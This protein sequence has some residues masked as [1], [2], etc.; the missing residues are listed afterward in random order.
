[1]REYW[2]PVA[3][4][5]RLISG[6]APVRLRILGE[7]LVAFRSPSGVVGVLD[8][9]CPHRGASLALARNEDCGLRCIYHGWKFASDGS[10]RE[11]PTHRPETD[12]SRFPKR[13][14]PVHE[15]QGIVW[16]WLGKGDAPA[17]PRL[18]FT[19]LPD[20]HVITSTAVLNCNWLHP[21]E[22]L[23]D[24]FHAQILH[25]QSNRASVRADVY[26]SDSVRDAD[27]DELRFDY[28][29]MHVQRTP[30]GFTYANIDV[31]KQTE[32]HFIAPFIQHHATTP[33][34]ETDKALQI[35]VP[36]DDD[37]CLLWIIFYN[38]F[39]PLKPDGFAMKGLGELPDLNNFMKGMDDRRAENFW[40]QNR[41][42]IDVGESFAGVTGMTGIALI[43]AE[44]VMAIESQGRVARSAEL[45]APTDRAVA[46]GRRTLVDA[47]KAY[48][49]G[50]S[51]LGRDLDL[52]KVEA[53]FASRK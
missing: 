21:L 53:S 5:A 17:F 43:L 14:Y 3:R 31:A 27:T 30:Y 48:E 25:K 39:G 24:V 12:L 7:N 20:D 47:V 35:S 46:E 1:M 8:E 29:E 52:S 16:A 40:G 41:E 2:I 26:F 36:I 6:A 37:H 45:L 33:G 22:T 34:I 28:P 23:W 42:A 11:A 51:P 10:L 50:S 38:R 9:A 18:S 13:G 32:F 19:D 15:G 44:D 49:A 4:S